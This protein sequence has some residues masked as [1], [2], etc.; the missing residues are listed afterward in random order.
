MIDNSGNQILI[1]DDIPANID[2]LIGFLNRRGYNILVA[3]DGESAIE[4]AVDNIPDLILLDIMLPGIDGFETCKH[5]KEFSETKDI[6]IIF[7]TA[8]SDIDD[9]VRGFKVGGV[10]YIT[11][12]IQKDEVLARINNHLMLRNLQQELKATNALLEKKVEE[13]T[14][15][16]KQSNAALQEEVK[17]RKQTERTLLETLEE[18]EKLKNILYD[19][20]LYLQEEIK[21]SH[22]F[23]EIIS[24]SECFIKILHQIEQVSLTDSTVLIL[25]ET[26]TGKELIA[27]AVHNI[28][29]RRNKTLVKVNCAALPANLIESELFGHEKGAFTGAIIR[30]I[31]R[32]ELANS[33]TI[34]LDEIGDLPLELQVKLLRVLQDGEFERLGDTKTLKVNVRVIAATNVNILEYIKEGKFRQDLYYRLNVFPLIVPPLRERTD[35]IPIL[36]QHFVKKY[37][38]KIGKYFDYVPESIISKLKNYSWPGNI[39]E[40]E[41]VIERAVILSTG[42]KLIINDPLISIINSPDNIIPNMEKLVDVEREHIIKAL[43][44]CNWVVE[45]KRGAAKYLDLAPSTLRDRMKKLG[46]Q[47]E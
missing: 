14:I 12:P 17:I 7:M 24:Q 47:R 31:G 23:D 41:N 1:V 21:L 35:D 2:V 36:V 11:K 15:E 28:S 44:H 10:D 4:I 19:E 45:G 39:R 46:I 30:R 9:K 32:F 42:N 20:K 5:L 38:S 3:E 6:P 33:G 22:N 34:F 13:R 16:L 27:R 43:E 37:S 25:G 18:I 8:L 29:P 40:L 26:G